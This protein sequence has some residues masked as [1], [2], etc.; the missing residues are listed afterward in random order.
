VADRIKK[1]MSD[2]KVR[3]I[4]REV[5]KNVKDFAQNVENLVDKVVSGESSDHRLYPAPALTIALFPA[6]LL[7]DKVISSEPS[8]F[9]PPSMAFALRLA[10][11]GQRSFPGSWPCSCN[12]PGHV[13]M[14]YAPGTPHGACLLCFLPRLPLLPSHC[15]F[16]QTCERPLFLPVPNCA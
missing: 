9:G 3:M 2:T 15:F 10:W 16:S 6:G 4:P 1:H 13:P 5:E 8:I 11:P 12:A 7:V 14:A